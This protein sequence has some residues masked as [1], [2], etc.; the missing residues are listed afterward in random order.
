MDALRVTAELV[1]GYVASD[2]WSPALDGIL[3]AIVL[4][5]RLGEEEYALGMTGQRPLVAP[6]LPLERVAHGEHWWWSASAPIVGD[7]LQF[8]RWFHRRFDA[9]HAYGRVEERT[10]RVLVAGGAYKNYRNRD[11]VTV[12]LDGTVTWHVIGDGVEVER[13][14]R[15]CGA[16][17]R[18]TARG[19]G[20]VR[21][22]RVTAD[23]DPRVARLHRPLPAD[24]ALAVGVT[25][26]ARVWGIRP[27]GRA[28]EHQVLAVLP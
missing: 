8:E 26:V 9:G 12:P 1:H 4:R 25:G 6:D 23:G 16:I 28:P 24:Y 11:L 20:A 17:G 2:P 10:R 14:L 7:T 13:L 18:G 22:W 15:R 5:E 3:A 27:P 21:A 19:Q